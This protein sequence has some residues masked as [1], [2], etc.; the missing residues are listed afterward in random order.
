MLTDWPLIVRFPVQFLAFIWVMGIPG[1]TAAAWLLDRKKAHP[2]AALALGLGTGLMVVPVLGQAY[3][4]FTGDYYRPWVMFAGAALV[5]AGAAWL[6]FK[7]LRLRL[8]WGSW[9]FWAIFGVVAAAAFFT[10]DPR[11]VFSN[12]LE[13][14]VA[15]TADCFRRGTMIYVGLPS[16]AREFTEPPS[17][18]PGT[19]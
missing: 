1:L 6:W 14:Q 17:A 15:G 11:H 8:E 5:N 16:A 18:I 12:F 3:V 7:G 9:Q 13:F 4:V 19:A 2:A 10:H